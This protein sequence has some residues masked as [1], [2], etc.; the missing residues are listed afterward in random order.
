[1]KSSTSALGTKILANALVLIGLAFFATGIF[2]QSPEAKGTPEPKGT[3]EQMASR[4]L[5]HLTKSLT[6]SADQSSKIKPIL[7][8]NAKEMAKIREEKKGD[9]KAAMIAA[10]ER[11]EATDK[12]ITALL[13]PEQQTKFAQQ[14]EKM[15]G[16]MERKANKK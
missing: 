10:K 7:E 11:I 14:R 1:M 8:N 2:A 13:T 3:P 9:R 6:L 15:R 16:R 12:E 5:T 4:R